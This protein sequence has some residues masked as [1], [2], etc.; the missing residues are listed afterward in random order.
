MGL[1]GGLFTDVGLEIERSCPATGYGDFDVF[2]GE[3]TFD[4]WNRQHMPGA[5]MIL[6][7]RRRQNHY[8]LTD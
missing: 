3:K 2:E 1:D 8:L 7:R 4:M 6:L 5:L